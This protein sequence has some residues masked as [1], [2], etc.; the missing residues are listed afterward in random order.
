MFLDD[1]L[2][3]MCRTFD[4]NQKVSVLHNALIDEC[5]DYY[6][7]KITPAM[8]KKEVKAILDKTFNLWDSFTRMTRVDTNEKVKTMGEV[9]ALFTFRKCF[10]DIPELKELYNSL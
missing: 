6:K 10:M 5:Q 4:Y 7:S 9:C 3:E 8:P 2:L 1:K